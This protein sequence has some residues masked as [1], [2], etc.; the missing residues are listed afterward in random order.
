MLFCQSFVPAVVQGAGAHPES[1]NSGIEGAGM[2][3]A[4]A[5]LPS[6]KANRAQS[7]AKTGDGL[8]TLLVQK[9]P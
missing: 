2:E 9:C 3:D 4:D 5:G 1:R 8:G 7:Q 6:T